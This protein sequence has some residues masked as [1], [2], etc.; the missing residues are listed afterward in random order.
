MS[1]TPN[2]ARRSFPAAWLLLLLLPAGFL[3]GR[4]V[5]GLNEPAAV[6]APAADPAAPGT[7]GSGGVKWVALD[8]AIEESRR[9]GKP[10]LLD[11]NADWCPPCRR[12]KEDVFENP[13]HAR[14]VEAAVVPVSVVDRYRETGANPP[15][16]EELQ[17]RFGIEAFPTLVAFSP[18]TGRFVKDAGFGGAAYT[19]EWIADAAR[20]VK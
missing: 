14:A 18:A 1:Q 10:V 17:R 6:T 8:A 12:M 20:Q 3:G 2:P 16:V 15:E 9:S 4:L 5:A 7:A 13:A 19:V 11:F